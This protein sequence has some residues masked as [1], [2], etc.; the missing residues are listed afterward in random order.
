MCGIKLSNSTALTRHKQLLHIRNHVEA[1]FINGEPCGKAVAEGDSDGQIQKQKAKKKK[2][3]SQEA[4]YM[5]KTKITR[6]EKNIPSNGSTRTTRK[7]IRLQKN[8][9]INDSS[10]WESLSCKWIQPNKG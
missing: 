5:T 1:M 7:T 10:E 4:T 9:K 2:G 3:P 6:Q 8:K